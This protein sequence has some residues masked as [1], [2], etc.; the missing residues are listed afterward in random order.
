EITDLGLAAG[1]GIAAQGPGPFVSGGDVARG[2]AG[3]DDGG[4][5]GAVDACTAVAVERCLPQDLAVL[6][7]YLRV[8]VR[9]HFVDDGGELVDK[10]PHRESGLPALQDEEDRSQMELDVPVDGIGDVRLDLGVEGAL[11]HV[12]RDR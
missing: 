5:L 4:R 10:L 2:P 11:Q 6:P 1:S 7:P 8:Q 9:M 3:H 12:L